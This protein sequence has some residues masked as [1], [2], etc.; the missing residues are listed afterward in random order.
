MSV[1]SV[2]GVHLSTT[3]TLTTELVQMALELCIQ[4]FLGSD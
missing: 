4:G 3:L 1:Q 2:C